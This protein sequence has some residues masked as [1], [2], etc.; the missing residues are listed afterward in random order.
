MEELHRKAE[1]LHGRNARFDPAEDGAAEAELAVEVDAEADAVL[2]DVAGI[3]VLLLGTGAAAGPEILHPGR[4]EGGGFH[5]ADDLAEPDMGHGVFAEEQIG[6]PEL[7]TGP[8]EILEVIHE[9]MVA[10]IGGPGNPH[11]WRGK[12]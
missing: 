10:G 11:F 8:A 9:P 2:G 4:F 6:G 5:G 12:V 7:P 3:M 1:V